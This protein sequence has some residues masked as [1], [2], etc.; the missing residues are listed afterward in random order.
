MYGGVVRAG[1]HL[2]FVGVV[3]ASVASA[4]RAFQKGTDCHHWYTCAY[5][6][7]ANRDRILKHI[8]TATDC[9]AIEYQYALALAAAPR[10]PPHDCA[11]EQ[12]IDALASSELTCETPA[13]VLPACNHTPLFTRHDTLFYGIIGGLALFSNATFM[14]LHHKELSALI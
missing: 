5:N 11:D 2:F 12:L 10:T 4:S 9:D 8:A 13:D 7:P 14:F 3:F 1:W 6:R